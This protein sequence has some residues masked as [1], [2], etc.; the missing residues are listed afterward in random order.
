MTIDIDEQQL[1]IDGVPSRRQ[2]R[3]ARLLKRRL[4]L[5]LIIVPLVLT[6][7]LVGLSRLGGGGATKGA[8]GGAEAGKPATYLVMTVRTGDLSGQADTLTLFHAGAGAKPYVL[9]IPASTLTEIPGYGFDIAGR[10]LS[11]GRIPLAELAV[12]NMVG[13]RI[14]HTAVFDGP[15]IARLVDRAGGIE[16]DVAGDLFQADKRGRFVPVFTAGRARFDGKRALRYLTFEG[17]DETELSRLARQQ[18]IWEALFAR[19]AGSRSDDLADAVAGLGSGVDGDRPVAEFGRFLAT[20]AASGSKD[21]T[22]DVMPV[23]PVGG[24][25]PA[26]EAFRLDVESLAAQINGFFGR[27]LLG[28]GDRPRLQLLNGNGTP[29]AGIAVAQ[30]LIPAG[31]YLVDTGNARSFNFA[32]TKIVIYSREAEAQAMAERLR[33]LLK[34]GEIE[35]G[36][37]P[38]TSVD[39]T[40]VIGKDFRTS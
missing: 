36:L 37:R 24:D 1:D 39:V 7:G 32:R 18:Q 33:K 8:A 40:V 6:V 28:G 34:L 15:A 27:M 2:R 23:T 11:F 3:R 35:I 14:D 13:V 5:A 9:L 38:Q 30:R 26:G 10:A 21:R 17:Q 31:F 25:G 4:R 29:E 16:V 19:F 22:Y 20:F 12:E